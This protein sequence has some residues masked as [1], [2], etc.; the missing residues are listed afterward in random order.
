MYKGDLKNLI[1]M[2]RKYGSDAEYVLAGGGNTSYKTGDTLYVKASGVS[3]GNIDEREFV[4]MNRAALDAMWD[5]EYSADEKTRESQVLTD[6]MKARLNP[7]Q[8]LRPSVE[9]LLH[10]L[11]PQKYVLHV[12]PALI[13]GLTCSK[14]GR[15]MSDELFPDA[16]WVPITKP[17]YVLAALCR[18]MMG[19]YRKKHGEDLQVMLLQN[20]GVFFAADSTEQIDI[21]VDKTVNTLKKAVVQ[22]I[23]KTDFTEQCAGIAAA[24]APAVRMLYKRFEQVDGSQ[25]RYFVDPLVS[26]YIESAE[27]FKLFDNPPSPDHIVYCK[28]KPLYIPFDRDIEKFYRELEKAFDEFVNENKYAPKIV[29]VQNVGIFACGKNIKEAETARALFEDEVKVA[30]FSVAFGGYLPMTKE[31]TDFIINWESESYRQKAGLSV[32]QK[33]LSG[34]VVVVTGSA[35]GFGKGIAEQL[36]SEGAYVVIADMNLKGAKQV[37]QEICKQCGEGSAIAVDVDVTDE[38]SVKSLIEKAVL[39]YGG[40]DLFISNA[41]I[42]R[43]GGLE[44]LTKSSFEL[45]TNVNYVAYFLCTK[46]ATV[47][48][49]IQHRF[50]PDETFDII[51]INSKSGL[52]GSNKNFAY[53]GSKFGGIGLTQSFALELAEFNIKCN[54]VCPG[55]YLDGPLWSDP[56]KGLFVQYFRAGK[57]PGAKSVDDVRKYY[58]SKVPLKRGCLPSDVTRAIL[59]AVDQKYETGQAIPVTGGQQMLK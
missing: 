23:P 56:E 5:E 19:E 33:R 18:K 42:V 32:S 20:H 22:A 11:F 30:E 15:K 24:I 16:L 59:Y 14:D 13:N 29:G 28:A 21:L 52:T 4:S 40:L 48:M 6:L 26:K 46:Y 36:A 57:V 54:A 10:N 34:K 55:N 35:Q 2:S 49:K 51:E 31:L 37:S 47:P 39:H 17:G 50:A 1:N 25:V 44:E 53:A 58:E 27:M 8:C 38:Q 9:T 3:L 43:A 7:E 12:H 45:V 41:G